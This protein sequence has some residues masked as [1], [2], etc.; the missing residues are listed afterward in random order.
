V[1]KLASL[2]GVGFLLGTRLF[3]FCFCREF[4]G[5]WEGVL[6]PLVPSTPLIIVLIDK[7]NQPHAI[8]A[9]FP[10]IVRHERYISIFVPP[11]A[12]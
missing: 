1:L 3:F 7:D 8:M 12:I 5:A 2:L 10:N 6:L 4:V 9:K 11:I